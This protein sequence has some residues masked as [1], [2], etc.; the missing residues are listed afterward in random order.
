M[1]SS[2]MDNDSDFK[3]QN[4]AMMVKDDGETSVASPDQV[5]KKEVTRREGV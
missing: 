5:A 1:K 2:S 4:E 3:S